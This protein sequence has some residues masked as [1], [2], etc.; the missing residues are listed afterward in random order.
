MATSLPE[1]IIVDSGRS[2]RIGGVASIAKLQPL[3]FGNY[4]KWRVEVEKCCC[5]IYLS[6]LQFLE[7]SASTGK[8]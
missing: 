5:G 7:I 8:K 2:D 1:D 3:H 4:D 6:Q